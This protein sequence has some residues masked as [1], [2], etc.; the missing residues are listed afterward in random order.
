M[1]L[2]LLLLARVCEGHKYVQVIVQTLKE[3]IIKVKNQRYIQLTI[4]YSR[5]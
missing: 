5:M 2:L 1:S 3:F 4:K